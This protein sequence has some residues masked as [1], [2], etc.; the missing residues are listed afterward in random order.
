M[1]I[2]NLANKY[3][4]NSANKYIRNLANITHIYSPYAADSLKV[5]QPLKCAIVVA[6]SSV[7]CRRDERKHCK[8][9]NYYVHAVEINNII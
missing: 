6:P 9:M 8:A 1:Y 5:Q 7:F 4:S 3:I 2:R